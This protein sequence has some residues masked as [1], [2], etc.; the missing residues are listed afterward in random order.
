MAALREIRVLVIEDDPD[1]RA[2]LRDILE[3]DGYVVEAASTVAEALDRDNWSEISTII[4]DYRLPDGSAETLLPRLRELAPKAAVIVSTGVAGLSGAILAVRQGAADYIVKP[5]DADALRAS[6]ARIADRQNLA[7][8]KERTEAAFRSLVE[9]AP[10]MIVIMRPDRTILYFSPFAEELTGYEANEVIGKN[11][12]SIFVPE[13]ETVEL[14]D[15]KFGRILAGTTTRGFECPVRC[16]NGSRRWMVWNA[17][18]LTNY[19]EGPSILAVG[20]DITTLKQAQ[21]QALQAERLAAIGQMVTG[22]AHESGNA[23]ARSQACL[24]MLSLEVEDRPEAQDLISRIQLAQDH[25]R[26]LYE[27]VRTYAAPLK[28]ELEEWSLSGI[29]RQAWQ[30]LALLRQGKSATLFEEIN[31][32]DVSCFVDQ[33][34]LEQV[35]RNILENSL[36]ASGDAAQIRV[37][38]SSTE[39]EGQPAIRIAIRDNGPGLTPEQRQRIFDPFFTTKTKGTGLG[40]A[41]AKR[42]VEAHCGQIDVGSGANPGAE[43]VVT[44]PYKK[45]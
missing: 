4:L 16:K 9:A 33:F 15:G 37:S 27:E 25:L 34:R 13:P 18:R 11:Y 32:Q 19:E 44:L 26:Q 7:R 36:A 28:L 2:N 23:L 30:N 12:L 8:A 35:F 3:L 22:L 20:Q 5:L 42:I 41:I 24:E 29:W 10:C 21:E 1:T 39:I 40:M 38:C 43:I 14:M 17:E 45:P 6:L 31:G